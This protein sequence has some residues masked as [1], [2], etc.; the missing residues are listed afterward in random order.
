MS[1]IEIKTDP[2]RKDLAWFGVILF[3]ALVWVG[4]VVARATHMPSVTWYVA[5]A[6]AALAI[7]YYVVPPIRRPMYIGWMYAV[8]PIGYVVS[9]VLL[10]ILYFGLLTPAGWLL[11]LFG[12]DPMQRRFDKSVKTYW[13]EREPKGKPADYFRQF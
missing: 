8:Y 12:H 9:H 10:G 7:V 5:V 6:A 13:T 1:L 3:L 4:F 2:S 11:R